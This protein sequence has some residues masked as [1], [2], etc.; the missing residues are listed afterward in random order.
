MNASHDA[1]ASQRRPLPALLDGV[2]GLIVPEL[3]RRLDEAGFGDQRPAHNSVFAHVP[4]EGIRLTELAQRARVSKQAMAELVDDLVGKGY[5]VKEPDPTDGRAKLINFTGRAYQA[6]PVA[7]DTFDAIEDEWA[8]T[9]GGDRIATLRATLEDLLD[10][11]G[12]NGLGP[13]P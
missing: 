1:L 10:A 8:R 12:Q 6:I 3:H 11:Y 4:P 2:V 13:Q 7:L 9:L 5:L